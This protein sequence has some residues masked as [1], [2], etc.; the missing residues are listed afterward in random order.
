VVLWLV[1]GPDGRAHDVRIRR[2]LGLGLDERAI[3]AVSQWKFEP[4]RKN[5]VPVAVRI[6][7]EVDFKLY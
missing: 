2:S 7:V 6:N 5:G 3:A 1:V 4:A